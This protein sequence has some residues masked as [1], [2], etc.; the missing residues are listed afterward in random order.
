MISSYHYPPTKIYNLVP[1][2]PRLG[3]T[4]V[5]RKKNGTMFYAECTS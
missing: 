5:L 4:V 2:D 1:L 3:E